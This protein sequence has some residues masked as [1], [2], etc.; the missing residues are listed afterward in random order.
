MATPEFPDWTPTPLKTLHEYYLRASDEGRVRPGAA[1]P[2][3]LSYRQ[4][5][6]ISEKLGR[7][8][9]MQRVWR[10]LERRALPHEPHYVHDFVSSVAEAVSWPEP[11]RKTAA[12]LRGEAKRIAELAREL[13]ARVEQFCP[14]TYEP[15]LNPF[16]FELLHPDLHQMLLRGIAA[17]KHT[18]AATWVCEHCAVLGTPE[19]DERTDHTQ[20][21]GPDLHRLSGALRRLVEVAEAGDSVLADPTLTVANP[22]AHNAKR[23]YFIRKLSGRVA[24][25]YGT[26]LYE[27]LAITARVMLDDSSINIQTVRNVLQR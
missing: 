25:Q 27:V 2:H 17:S 1:G 13:A 5:A 18:P 4:R 10:T 11:M 20:S 24:E 9:D 26:P 19:F 23:N 16:L 3:S 22:N 8:P 14:D 7:H 15:I 6:A 21:D 12:Q